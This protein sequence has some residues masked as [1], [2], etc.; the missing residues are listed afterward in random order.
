M[1]NEHFKSIIWPFVC[2]ITSSFLSHWLSTSGVSDQAGNGALMEFLIITPWIL[3]V[4]RYGFLAFAILS[5]ILL[6]L[7]ILEAMDVIDHI[8]IF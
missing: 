1:K 8:D 2:A 3:A 4:F 5:G 6:V 7:R